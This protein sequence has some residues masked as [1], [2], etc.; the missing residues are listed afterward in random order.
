[1]GFEKETSI[2]ASHQVGET[3]FYRQNRKGGPLKI[4][5]EKYLRADIGCGYELCKKCP[6]SP[7]FKPGSGSDLQILSSSFPYKHFVVPDAQFALRQLDV[8]EELSN[9]ILLQIVMDNVFK[10]NPPKYRRLRDGSKNRK[11]GYF[12][13]EHHQDTYVERY[14]NESVEER[15]QRAFMKSIQFFAKHFEDCGIRIVILSDHNDHYAKQSIQGVE[16]AT[17]EEYVA[18]LTGDIQGL[19]DKICRAPL[20]EDE[21]GAGEFVYPAHVDMKDVQNGIKSGK[22]LQGVYRSANFSEGFIRVD[23]DKLDLLEILIHGKDNINRASE[24]N[25]GINE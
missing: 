24:G 22:Y 16:V 11:F 5:R 18:G 25:I 20:N 14:P 13:N 7:F 21:A 17:C 23:S 2:Q 19:E 6:R 3:T 12:L 15:N 8:M 10:A 4:S 9:V 1:M